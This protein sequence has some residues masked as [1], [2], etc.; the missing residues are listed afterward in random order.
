MPLNS[1]PLPT[2]S[3]Q[4]FCLA[5]KAARERKGISLD[6]IEKATKIPAYMFAA[7]ERCDLRRWPTGLFRRSFFRDYVKMIGV[8][9]TEACAAFVQLFVEEKDVV[10]S[11]HQVVDGEVRKG[12]EGVQRGS[13]EVRRGSEGVLKGSGTAEAQP[14]PGV[15]LALDT[16][17]H[18]PRTPLVSRLLAAVIDAA[19]VV[20]IA[21][22]IAWAAGLDWSTTIAIVALAYLLL[23][24]GLFAES[25]AKW[26]FARRQVIVQR[27]RHGPAAVVAWKRHVVYSVRH[28]FDRGADASPDE[29]VD[30][31]RPVREWVS[32]ARRVGPPPA[33]RFR[34]RIKLPQ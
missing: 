8:P 15:R 1:E 13:E 11:L 21:V 6:E 32:D 23:E 20:V 16:A 27:L 10:A 7:L 22:A 17:W 9:V 30:E 4:D 26:I 31:E 24:T 25:P 5:L 2:D 3:R 29:H 18:G 33:A 14:G 28:M 19:T 12:S 34:V